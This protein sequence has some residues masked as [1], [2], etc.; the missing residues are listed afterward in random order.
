MGICIIFALDILHS[1]ETVVDRLID[2]SINLFFVTDMR[3][4]YMLKGLSSSFKVGFGIQ[5]SAYKA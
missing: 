3:E 2:L 5:S 4:T 1:I